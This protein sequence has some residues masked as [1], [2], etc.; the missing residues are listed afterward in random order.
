MK[1]SILIPHYKN[2]KI[3]AHCICQLLKNKGKHDIEIIVVSN[4]QK[5]GVEYLKPFRKYIKLVYYPKGVVQSHGIAFDFA[6]KNGLV[7]NENFITLESDSFPEKDKWLDYYENAVNEGYNAAGSHLLLSGGLYMHPCGAMYNKTVWQEAKEYCDNI[8]Y[9]YFPNMSKREGF[10]CH[11]MLH[12]SITDMVLSNPLDYVDLAKKYQ[13]KSIDEM[14]A[15]MGWYKPT[16]S[17][18]HNGMGSINESIK[19]YGKRNIQTDASNVLLDNKKKI[20]AR[21][22][23]EPGQWFTYYLYA[24]GESVENIP[25]EVKWLPNREGQQQEYTLTENGLKHIWAGSSFLDM[26]DTSMND[27]YEFKKN[28]IET[29][30][31]S[32]PEKYKIQQ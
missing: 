8:Q 13:G 32:L 30:Y 23:Y 15:I 12:K 26:K 17:P 10:D 20:I 31:N 11:L 28:Q 7:N 2:G 3:T 9:D 16:A 21:I 18:F 1:F 6:L 24:I 19:T 27:V 22:G 25:T 29:L 4:S 5:E 14:K